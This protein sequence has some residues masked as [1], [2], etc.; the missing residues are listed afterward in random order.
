MGR[1][2]TLGWAPPSASD[3]LPPASERSAR[4]PGVGWEDQACVLASARGH[5]GL[6]VTK[7]VVSMGGWQ[8]GGYKKV[9]KPWA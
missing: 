6:L 7:C 9:A 8:A 3:C 1:G 2:D 5:S 4:W